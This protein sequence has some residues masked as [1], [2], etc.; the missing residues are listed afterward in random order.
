MG[1][2][3]KKTRIKTPIPVLVAIIG[4]VGTLF[5]GLPEFLKLRKDPE[6]IANLELSLIKYDDPSGIF[7]IEYPSDCSVTNRGKRNP[8]NIEVEFLP[9][10]IVKIN[11]NIYWSPAPSL[12]IEVHSGL[13]TFPIYNNEDFIEQLKLMM[14]D[15]EDMIF[16]TNQ[17]TNK[18]YFAHYEDKLLGHK[19]QNFILYESENGAYVFVFI[20]VNGDFEYAIKSSER[21]LSSFQWSPSRV[22]EYFNK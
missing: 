7:T 3:K 18:G 16:I 4:L 20:Y 2:S 11:E 22:I 15:P 6:T 5:V 9:K 12:Y 17:R 8:T 19:I 1:N 21:I 14:T 13:D 10:N